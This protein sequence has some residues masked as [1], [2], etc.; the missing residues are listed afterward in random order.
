VLEAWNPT[1]RDAESTRQAVLAFLAASPDAC[2]RANTAGHITASAVVLTPDLSQVLLTLHPRIGRWVQLGGH[3]EPDDTTL[4]EAALRE[5]REESGIDDLT[6]D[7]NLHA[8][9]VHPLTCS[10]GIPT[11]HLDLQFRALAPAHAT[12]LRSPESLDL[13]WFPVTALPPNADVTL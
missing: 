8:L 9:H 6:L 3:C 10:L 13:R 2:L 1:G 11:R 7:E 12:P 4:P 5:A